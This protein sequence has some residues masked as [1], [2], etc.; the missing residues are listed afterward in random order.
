MIPP[1]FFKIIKETSSPSA[2][3]PSRFLNDIIQGFKR[4]LLRYKYEPRQRIIESSEE[5]ECTFKPQ[6]NTPSKSE[7]ESEEKHYE[8]LYKQ[9]E[10]AIRRKKLL[11][12]Q[13]EAAELKVAPI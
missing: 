3:S 6:I 8:L 9:A 2:K 10:E 5:M 4:R 13:K 12:E 11:Q 1:S 7:E